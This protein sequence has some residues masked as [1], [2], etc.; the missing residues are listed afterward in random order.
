MTYQQLEKCYKT[1]LKQR[2][3]AE[4]QLQIKDD[5]ESAH[6]PIEEHPNYEAFIRAF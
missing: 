6:N 4:L 3:D 1:V 2:D 5:P